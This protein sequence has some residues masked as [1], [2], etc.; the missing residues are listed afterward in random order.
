MNPKALKYS[1][2]LMASDGYSGSLE[3]YKSLITNNPKAQQYS[4]NLLKSDGYTGSIEDFSTLIGE[5]T[6]TPRKSKYLDFGEDE[7]VEE[8]ELAPELEERASNLF[9]GEIG[10]PKIGDADAGLGSGMTS[11]LKDKLGPT[12][13][14]ETRQKKIES[15]RVERDDILKGPN[16]GT[17][18]GYVEWTSSDET[19][20]PPSKIR[21]EI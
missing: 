10:V 11:V 9:G 7:E 17:W 1:Y 19:I 14:F 20:A 2:E 15:E 3:D 12:E 8:V 4:F 21:Y 18:E 6:T 5:G 13:D 16:A